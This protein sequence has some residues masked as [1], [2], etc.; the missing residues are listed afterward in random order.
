[1]VAIEPQVFD[2]LAYLVQHR[3]RVVTKDDL[4]TAVWNGRLVSESALTTRVNAVR[5]A[6]GDSG[7]AQRLIRTLRGRGIRFVGTVNE[8]QIA[9]TGADHE[10]QLR[11]PD[12]PPA[13]VRSRD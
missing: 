1:L 7:D 11:R 9:S 5:T 13:G 3:D 8:S 10:P 2:L 12:R 6:L 4:F